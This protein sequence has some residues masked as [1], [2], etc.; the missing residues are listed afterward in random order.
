MLCS[1]IVY[2]GLPVPNPVSTRNGRELLD[3]QNNRLQAASRNT[4]IEERENDTCNRH[5]HGEYSPG[6]D[7]SCPLHP[8]NPTVPYR[9]HGGTLREGIVDNGHVINIEHNGERSVHPPRRIH[10]VACPQYNH[11]NSQ[12]RYTGYTTRGF[13]S[14]ESVPLTNGGMVR[15]TGILDTEDQVDTQTTYIEGP[16]DEDNTTIEP[17]TIEQ[18]LGSFNLN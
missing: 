1:S 11:G 17:M 7:G 14:D 4:L 16:S 2:Q 3:Q 5:V 10:S 6:G 8:S 18:K 9:Q 15:D 12:D 13:T